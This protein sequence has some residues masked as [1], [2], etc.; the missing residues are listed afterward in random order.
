MVEQ[1]VGDRTELRRSRAPSYSQKVTGGMGVLQLA[2]IL[3]REM[4]ATI[5]IESH[6]A[7]GIVNRKGEHLLQHHLH[8]PPPP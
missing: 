5:F 3:G 6:A 4:D 2:K 8:V 1:P 7:I